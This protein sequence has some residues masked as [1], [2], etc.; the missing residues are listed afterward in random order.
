MIHGNLR[1]LRKQK[2]A[3]L[4]KGLWSPPSFPNKALLIEAWVAWGGGKTWPLRFSWTV[5]AVSRLGTNSNWDEFYRIRWGNKKPDAE[6]LPSNRRKWRFICGMFFLNVWAIHGLVSHHVLNFVSILSQIQLI[7]GFFTQFV[8]CV[9]EGFFWDDM[10]DC[11]SWPCF[12]CCPD[13]SVN[14]RYIE[15]S[16]M[17]LL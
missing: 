11:C 12:F 9:F 1:A 15:V 10:S 17:R 8:L 16:P 13:S 2:K 14:C 7:G 5:W 6:T 4:T 3:G